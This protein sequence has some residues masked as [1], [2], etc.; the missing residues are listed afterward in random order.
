MT[1]MIGFAVT[2]TAHRKLKTYCAQIGKSM[3]R[4]LTEYFQGLPATAPRTTNNETRL[5][6]IDP[7]RLIAHVDESLAIKFN[8]HCKKVGKSRD[9]VLDEFIQSL[10]KRPII[11]VRER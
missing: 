1:K 10:P 2:E 8:K 9:K 7:I 5:S 11:E 6:N 3:S 4:V